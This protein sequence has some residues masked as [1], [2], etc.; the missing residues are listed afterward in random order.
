MKINV[1]LQFCESLLVFKI[2]VIWFRNE[3][4]SSVH[5]QDE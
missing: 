4:K 1:V 2:C 3:R 5:L